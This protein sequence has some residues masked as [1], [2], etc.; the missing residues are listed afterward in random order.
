MGNI[1]IEDRIAKWH[2]KDVFVVDLIIDGNK[3]ETGN[4]PILSHCFWEDMN[5]QAQRALH[6]IE[7][8]NPQSTF[9]INISTMGMSDEEKENRFVSFVKNKFPDLEVDKI[10]DIINQEVSDIQFTG[11][12]DNHPNPFLKFPIDSQMTKHFI[13]KV[14]SEFIKV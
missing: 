14:I 5:D 10:L 1:E 6:R 3:I 2:D 13:L 11:P 12:D 4:M 8:N 9:D 7:K